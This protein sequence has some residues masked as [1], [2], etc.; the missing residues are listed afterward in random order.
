ME[1]KQ[2]TLRS[3][4]VQCPHCG[5]YYSVTY[6]YCPFCDAGRKAE[7][8]KKAARKQQAA[9]FFANIFSGK[10]DEEVE[11]P[12]GEAAPA[13]EAAPAREAGSV[14]ETA[15]EARQRR[16]QPPRQRPAADANPPRSD[17]FRRKKTSEMTDEEK[18]AYR[19]ERE[20]R[21][22]AR[23]RA[24]D[25][26]ARQSAV[27][28]T[29]ETAPI[30][31][32]KPQQSFVPPELDPM[33][34]EVMDLTMPAQDG[35]PGEE[36]QPALE[37]TEAAAPETAPQE[38]SPAEGSEWSLLSDLKLPP[39]AAEG[40]AAAPEIQDIPDA[41]VQA[42]DTTA[43]PEPPAEQPA[44]APPETILQGDSELDALLSEIRGMLDEPTVVP[45]AQA[46]QSAQSAANAVA[47]A[48]AQA[49]AQGMPTVAEGAGEAAAAVQDDGPTLFSDF[50]PPPAAPSQEAEQAA[51]VRRERRQAA[52]KKRFPLIPVVAGVVIVVVVALLVSHGLSSREPVLADT[53]TMQQ[54]ELTMTKPGQIEP[55]TPV[56]SPKKSTAELKWSCTN[57]SV[58]TVDPQGVVEALAPGTATVSATM[59]NG[60]SAQCEITC[61]WDETREP[62]VE[63]EGETGVM[64]LSSTN[65]TLDGEGKTQQLAMEGTDA[66]VTWS[67]DKASVATVSADGT[68]TAVS[69]GSATITAQVDGQTFKCDVLCMW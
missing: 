9:S 58:V 46:V 32:A 19:A 1:S 33:E 35:M 54:T 39:E 48:Q 34:T 8:R 13:W 12:I 40:N 28:E 15:H 7:E 18:A 25:Q 22:A 21:A 65:L 64:K 24:R 2:M 60:E 20:A 51:P 23:K 16:S 5:E 31:D 11:A 49:D 4:T 69:K 10:E 59:A 26:A 62:S 66:N 61:V 42:E 67:S 36:V 14:P 17:G 55:L 53:V 27:L 68:V 29:A 45:A 57:W 52:K 38:E 37:E 41:P 6:K 63:G 50:L 56:F 43:A 30:F 44:E 47:E 3:Q